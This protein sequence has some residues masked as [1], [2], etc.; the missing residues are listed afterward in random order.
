[1]YTGAPNIFTTHAFFRDVTG[2]LQ[3]LG[4]LGGS[5]SSAQH[6]NN[7]GQIVGSSLTSGDAASHAFLYQGG[8]MIDLNTLIPADSG[9]VLQ[10]ASWINDLGQIVGGG[11]LNGVSAAFRLDPGGSVGVNILLSELANGSLQLTAGDMSSL[12]AKLQS[13]LASI[14]RSNV[15]A[16]GGKLGAFINQVQAM[17][18]SGRLDAGTGAALISGANNVMN[19]Q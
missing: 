1:M 6:I 19:N 4:T 3:D 14:D 15:T 9:W 18:N 8:T 5:S 16:T 10:G 2:S 11:T 13:A 17:V 7:E 12:S